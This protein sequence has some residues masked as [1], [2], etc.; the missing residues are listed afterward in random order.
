MD[1]EDVNPAECRTPLVADLVALCRELNATGSRYLI[2][3]GF[4]VI[5]YGYI[6]TTGDIDVLLDGDME[7]QKAVRRAMESLPD[8]AILELG[9]EEDF[10]EWVVVR[11]ADEVLVDLMIAACGI[12]YAEASRE[13]RVIDIDGV[14]IP[15]A[16]PKLLLRM[17]QTYRAKDEEDRIFLQYKIAQEEGRAPEL[18]PG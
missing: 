14:P 5:Q 1:D 15:F 18:P 16:S 8:K 12:E 13:I 4:A 10:R 3:G 17:K 2:I 11:V 7:N 9:P 6:R